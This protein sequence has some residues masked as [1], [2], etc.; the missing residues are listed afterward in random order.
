MRRASISEPSDTDPEP[1]T[2]DP[3]PAGELAHRQPPCPRPVRS[4]LLAGRTFIFGGV[5]HCEGPRP[6]SF[7]LVWGKEKRLLLGSTFQRVFQRT[8]FL[9]DVRGQVM[10]GFRGP[11]S[12]GKAVLNE[13]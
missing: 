1:R 11:I 6:S 8:L 12:L 2:L 3:S 4:S 10:K 9:L 13:S 5:E 7:L